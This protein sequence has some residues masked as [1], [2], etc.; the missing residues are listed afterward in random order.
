MIQEDNNVLDELKT[1]INNE[2]YKK[3]II[4]LRR[5]IIN[6]VV[7]DIKKE[8]PKYEFTTIF[9]LVDKTEK[10][11]YK[12]KRAVKNIYTSD[13]YYDI[14]EVSE[15]IEMYEKIKKGK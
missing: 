3:A 13:E 6:L 11:S 9:D 15:L 1:Y 14:D 7:K 2:D 5:E 12:Y 10:M 8:D 4:I